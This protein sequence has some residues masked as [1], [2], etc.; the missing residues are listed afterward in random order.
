MT[1]KAE[2]LSGSTRLRYGWPSLVVAVI[3]GLLFAYVLW[4]AIGN[5]VALPATFGSV[6]P[7]WL[8]VLD[9]ALPPV[10]YAVA[11]LLGRRRDLLLRTV[12]FFIGLTVISCATVASIA[13]VQ[14]HFGL[15]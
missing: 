9:F 7:W 13:Y 6:T 11:F 15:V 2:P 12:F 1:D 3:F 10:V 8:L 5:L 14:T 4:T